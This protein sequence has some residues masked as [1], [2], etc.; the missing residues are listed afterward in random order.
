MK[1]RLG[2]LQMSIL[3]RISN[4]TNS[5]ENKE[6]KV[7]KEVQKL[8]HSIE[9]DLANIKIK[10]SKTEVERNRLKRELDECTNEKRKM[11]TYIEKTRQSGNESEALI[12][13]T[14]KEDLEEKE[15]ALKTT[16]E[17]M[18]SNQLKMN[19]SQEVLTS[20]VED[21]RERK[22]SIDIKIE[23]AKLQEKLNDINSGTFTDMEKDA[24]RILDEAE[25]M[26]ELNEIERGN[27]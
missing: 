7:N 26:A 13:I 9:E 15:K 3:K 11:E 25:A 27:F 21:L 6:K 8:I 19:Q 16:Y 23:K 2:G 14:K 22:T 17:R 1:N 4:L 18:A 12:Y 20:K 5:S 24:T 10:S